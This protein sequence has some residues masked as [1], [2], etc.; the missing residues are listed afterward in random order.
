M[1]WTMMI[2]CYWRLN[3]LCSLAPYS[4]LVS[5]MY[6]LTVR[7]ADALFLTLNGW[8]PSSPLSIERLWVCLPKFWSQDLFF[9][10]KHSFF[11]PHDSFLHNKGDAKY[12]SLSLLRVVSCALFLNCFPLEST[13]KDMDQLFYLGKRLK[14]KEAYSWAFLDNIQIFLKK[15]PQQQN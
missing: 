10:S 5:S 11:L 15:R 4:K 9:L 6:N 7:W 12:F 1:Y 14:P 2:C 8:S 13:V 3:C